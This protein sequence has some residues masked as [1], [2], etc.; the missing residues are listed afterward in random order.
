MENQPQGFKD[1]VILQSYIENKPICL[2]LFHR[3]IYI[4]TGSSLEFVDRFYSPVL[5]EDLKDLFTLNDQALANRL[6]KIN[7]YEQAINGNMFVECFLK[8]Q[9]VCGSTSDA[10][11]TN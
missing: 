3:L 11:R 8:R 2:G 4:P 10:I 7:R 9:G 6:A 5:R 1:I